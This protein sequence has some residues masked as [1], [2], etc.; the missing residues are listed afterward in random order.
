M[1][2]LD[3]SDEKLLASS[4]RH[5]QA[6]ELARPARPV[7][8]QLQRMM[9]LPAPVWENQERS[10]VTD[11][12]CIV[13]SGA[14]RCTGIASHSAWIGC[15]VGE[16]LDKSD[17]CEVHASQLLATMDTERESKYS[18]RRCWDA[19][20]VISK[21]RVIRIERIDHDDDEDPA[22]APGRLAG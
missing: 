17:V 22:S 19:V 14:A 1:P 6:L 16:H 10:K 8:D 13:F 20:G 18:C 11:G 9:G 15:T 21:A 7:T 3:D 12:R 4:G 2:Y 5:A